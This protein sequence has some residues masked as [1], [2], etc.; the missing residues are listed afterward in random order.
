MKT[1]VMLTSLTDDRVGVLVDVLEELLQTLQAA[2]AAL[3]ARL[4]PAARLV[5]L[6]SVAQV[7]KTKSTGNK[8]E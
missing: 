7:S 3:V 4:R 2:D 8:G 1:D 6:Q 5:L